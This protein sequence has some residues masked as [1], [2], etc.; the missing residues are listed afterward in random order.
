MTD[1][2]NP[3]DPSVRAALEVRCSMCGANPGDWC[4]NLTG[5]PLGRIV[6]IYRVPL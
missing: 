4:R 1:L 6:H 5:L 3:A 2:S